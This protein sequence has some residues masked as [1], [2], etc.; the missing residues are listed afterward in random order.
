MGSGFGDVDN[1][2]TGNRN[3]SHFWCADETGG[4]RVSKNIRFTKS[5][6]EKNGVKSKIY[7]VLQKSAKNTMS[8][9]YFVSFF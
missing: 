9:T 4:G 7:M 2:L 5:C 8:G 3:S 6:I 1:Y